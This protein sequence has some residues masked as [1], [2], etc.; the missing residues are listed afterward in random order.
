MGV[1]QANNDIRMLRNKEKEEIDRILLELS[2]MAGNC[3]DSIIGSYQ[4][5]IDLNVI[6]AKGNLA[7]TMKTVTPIVND[8]GYINLKKARHPLIDKEKVVPVDITLGKDYTLLVITGPNTGGKTVS[9]KTTGLLTLMAMSGLMIP[10]GDESEI[11]VFKKILVDIG[12]EQSIQLFL[13]I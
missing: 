7:Y 6:F 8:K 5:L 4:N 9:L 2:S 11:S 10:C 1:V 13:L 12:D 3:A